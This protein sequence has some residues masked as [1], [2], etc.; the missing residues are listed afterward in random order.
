MAAPPDLPLLRA[1][2]DRAVAAVSSPRVRK[3][4]GVPGVLRFAQVAV[5]RR[6][7]R[8]WKRTAPL[9]I[10]GEM[11]VVLPETISEAIYLYGFFAD[12]LTHLALANVRPGDV[13]LDVGAHFGY[14]SLV[15]STLAGERGHV[16]SFEP[17][18][19][20]F[21]MLQEN[22]ARRANITPLPSAAG[23]EPGELQLTAYDLRY[24]AW[25]TLSGET[26]LP[27]GLANEERRISVRVLRLDD[28]VRERGIVPTVIKIDAENF[29]DR[30]V[31]GLCDTIATHRPRFIL[32]T[33]SAASLGAGEALAAAGYDVHCY[34]GDGVI[35]R[36]PGTLA[37]ANATGLD[38]LFLPEGA[39]YD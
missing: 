33:G 20:T 15:C 13:V 38:L 28:F 1:R 24:I 34:M 12:G 36:W 17:T 27:P 3:L 7:R 26:R 25:N 22:A 21:G 8:P 11:T 31:R 23:D 10:G 35:A 39:S 19:A 18:P 16:Y 37:E 9:V 6:L 2:L 29:E 4:F 14:F 30:V 5:A 32:E